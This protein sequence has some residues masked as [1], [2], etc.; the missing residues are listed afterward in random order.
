MDSNHW[1]HRGFKLEDNI[2]VG[3]NIG[4]GKNWQL[5]K[6]NDEQYVLFADPALISKWDSDSLLSSS[7]FSQVD[8]ENGSLEYLLSGSG[9]LI[10]SVEL[11]PFP[12]NYKQA[13]TFAK[14][15][16]SAREKGIKLSFADGLFIEKYGSLLPTYTEELIADDYVLGSFLTAGVNTSVFDA[17]KFVRFMSWL[18]PDAI[19]D[20]LKASNLEIPKQIVIQEKKLSPEVESSRSDNNTK[21]NRFKLPGR[22][23]LES[24]FNEHIVDVILNAEKYKRMGIDFPSA[25]ILH[26]LPGSGKT[27]AVER[28]AEFLGWPTYRI[29]SGTI[30][31][32]YI[33][34][35]SKKIADIFD[36]A[37]ENAPSIMIVDEME[38][39]LTDRGASA[40]TGTHHL[41]EVAE[42]LRK[43]PE[44]TSKHVLIFAMTNMIDSIDPAILRRGRFDHIIEVKMPS[45][46]DVAMLLQKEFQ[47]LPIS[48]DVSIEDLAELLQGHPMSDV[49]YVIK[50]AGRLAAKTD[51][52]Y[53]T[54]DI[55]LTACNSLPHSE[56][57]PKRKIG[58]AID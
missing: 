42:F 9:N 21:D 39:F 36:S 53:I 25:V 54:Q 35:T 46:K 7:L 32:S 23:E 19:A 5:Y 22:P 11:G 50:E 44:A 29:D 27:F 13:R 56:E 18:S 48:V 10:S 4:I 49:S 14:A 57:K 8:G 52:E 24:F 26:G 40:V 37:I 31:S 12:E 17:D 3:K 28:L 58:F 38:A 41:E 15:M 55:F 34:E 2:F 1:V 6:T 30:G 47:R 33:H 43:I 51:S 45:K 20:I 16:A